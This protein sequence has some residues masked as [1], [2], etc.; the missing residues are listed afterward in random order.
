MYLKHL[1]GRNV[2]KAFTL[3]ELLVVLI[4]IGILVLLAIPSLM[5]LISK[6]RSTEAKLQ[7]NSLYTYQKT[8]FFE[9]ATYSHSL[10]EIG[11]EQMKLSTEGGQANYKIEIIDASN[12]GFKARA[13]AVVDFD[14]DGVMNTWEINHD[15]QLK[16]TQKD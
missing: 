14:G 5:P 10:E 9:T 12:K 8:Y 16:E 2:L 13:T 3:N 6:A 11:F 4:I 1:S 7:L 15:N